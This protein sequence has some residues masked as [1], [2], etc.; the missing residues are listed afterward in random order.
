MSEAVKVGD[1]FIF[2]EGSYIVVTDPF[3][4]NDRTQMVLVLESEAPGVPQKNYGIVKDD[5]KFAKQ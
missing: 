3:W 5:W 4:V 2:D 1:L